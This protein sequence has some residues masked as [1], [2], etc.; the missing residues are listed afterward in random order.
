MSRY[1]DYYVTQAE[2]WPV[3]EE[4]GLVPPRL[5]ATQEQENAVSD[6]VDWINE[7]I[8]CDIANPTPRP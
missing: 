2:L 7:A 5:A 1:P 6:V 3:L 4:A 8:V